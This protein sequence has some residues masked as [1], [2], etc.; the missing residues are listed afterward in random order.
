M[1]VQPFLKVRDD[2]PH[3]HV[4]QRRAGRRR[5][6]TSHR[7]VAVLQ[8]TFNVLGGLWPIASLR[9]FEWVYGKKQDVFLPN[10]H[11]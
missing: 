5:G 1:G 8:G 2:L 11:T 9:N 3:L 6:L 4:A 10:E 7:E